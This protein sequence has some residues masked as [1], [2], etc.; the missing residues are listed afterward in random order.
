MR[1]TIQPLSC[2]LSEMK[3]GS[4]PEK[5]VMHIAHNIIVETSTFLKLSSQYQRLSTHC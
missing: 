4:Y 3:Y 5:H 2:I 1:E